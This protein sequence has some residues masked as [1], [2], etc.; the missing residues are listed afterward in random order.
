MDKAD[1]ESRFNHHPPSPE[2]AAAHAEIRGRCLNLANDINQA[3]PES[4]EK[5]LA[6]TNL[7]QV[8]FWANAALARTPA[9]D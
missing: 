1:L 3:L 9:K 7:E 4:R 2:K 5:S 6:I 8:M